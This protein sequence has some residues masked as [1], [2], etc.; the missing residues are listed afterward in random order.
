MSPKDWMPTKQTL[1]LA[2]IMACGLTLI[3]ATTYVI[4][5]RMVH[6]RHRGS[7][8]SKALEES[9]DEY[10]SEEEMD[11][12]DYHVANKL[13]LRRRFAQ[14]S[15]PLITFGELYEHALMLDT[16]RKSKLITKIYFDSN[17]EYVREE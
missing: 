11:W 3:G 15:M 17:D 7:K 8:K 9:D 4:T 12:E 5:S 2:G 14:R 10:M 13:R 6:H 1:G 16:T